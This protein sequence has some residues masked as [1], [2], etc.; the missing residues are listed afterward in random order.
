LARTFPHGSPESAILFKLFMAGYII[1]EGGASDRQRIS[2]ATSKN[3]DIPNCR[4]GERCPEALQEAKK[5]YLKDGRQLR[6]LS[7]TYNCIG[8]V[9]ANRRTW[10]DPEIVPMILSDDEYKQVPE[11]DVMEGDIVLYQSDRDRKLSHVGLVVSKEPN[12][13]A[14]TWSIRVL[15]QWGADGEY[16][17]DYRDVPEA[18]GRPIGFYSERRKG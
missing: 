10:I 5:I 1:L 6:S 9:F 12:L 16:F 14:G 15:S 2:L 11:A 4:R 8:M 18:L 3:N 17:H 7:A 13:E